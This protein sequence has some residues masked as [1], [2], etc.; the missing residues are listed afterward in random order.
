TFSA[1]LARTGDLRRPD[2][3]RPAQRADRTSAISPRVT[4]HP[5]ASDPRKGG[6]SGRER[7]G[8]VPV[9]FARPGGR[10]VGSDITSGVRRPGMSPLRRGGLMGPWHDSRYT[11]LFTRF[12][13]V[14]RQAHDPAVWMCAGT[15][16]PWGARP[17]ALAIGGAGWERPDA[18]AAC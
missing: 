8:G 13:P 16:P 3:T 4:R 6:P 5:C 7:A 1:P 12:G 17:Q 14:P 18:E 15:L 10:V 9:P 2:R 11:G